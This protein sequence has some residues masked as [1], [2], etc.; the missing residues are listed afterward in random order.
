MKPRLTIAACG[1]LGVMLMSQPSDAQKSDPARLRGALTALAQDESAWKTFSVT[2]DDMHGLHGGL[3]LTIHGDGRVEQK[4]VREKAGAPKQSVSRADLQR[5]V[6]LLIELAA[7]DQRVPARRPVPD[8]SRAN[9]RI[10]LDG[11]TS[12]IWEWFNDLEKHQRISRVRQLMKDI[13]WK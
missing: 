6:A 8:E 5:L 7:W 2:Y 11:N 3:T 4:A 12:V 1:L 9:L 13:A 10:T